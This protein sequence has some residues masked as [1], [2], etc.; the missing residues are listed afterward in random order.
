MGLTI[1]AFAFISMVSSS[2]FPAVYA[3]K[4]PP[5]DPEEGED[6]ETNGAKGGNPNNSEQAQENADERHIERILKEEEAFADDNPNN[7]HG[8][9]TAHIKTFHN[10]RGVE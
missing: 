6:C 2:V 8:A 10:E 4:E 9:L 7:D 5:C 1:G 3:V